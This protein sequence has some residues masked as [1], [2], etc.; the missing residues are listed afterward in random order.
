MPIVDV[1]NVENAG[2]FFHPITYTMQVSQKTMG[3]LEI[4]MKKNLVHH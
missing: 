3:F 4:S 2:V 1:V